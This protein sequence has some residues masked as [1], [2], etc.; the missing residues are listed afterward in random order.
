VL[1]VNLGAVHSLWLKQHGEDQGLKLSTFID[2][3][4]ELTC[5]YRDFREGER[6]PLTE[7]EQFWALTGETPESL[8]PGKLITAK[9]VWVQAECA[10]LKTDSG[11]CRAFLL[12]RLLPEN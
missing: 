10:G 1:Q 5:Q 3:S 8:R 7:E 6:A 12:S 2:L 11:V 4:M 9:V